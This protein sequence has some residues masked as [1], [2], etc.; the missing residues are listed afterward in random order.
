MQ[1]ACLW[2]SGH[3]PCVP[4]LLELVV[5][6]LMGAGVAVNLLL[7]HSAKVPHG[8][9]GDRGSRLTLGLVPAHARRP[10]HFV[11]LVPVHSNG[12]VAGVGTMPPGV[13]P[14]HWTQH[15]LLCWGHLV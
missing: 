13:A 5:Y 15:R 14:C 11:K 6:P 12:M 8:S 2:F 3:L 1:V 7:L 9:R 10:K 4:L